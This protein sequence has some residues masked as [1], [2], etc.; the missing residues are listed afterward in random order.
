VIHAR[1]RAGIC[2]AAVLALVATAATDLVVLSTRHP[3]HTP[4]VAAR[5][6]RPAPSHSPLPPALAAPDLALPSHSVPPV[7]AADLRRTRSAPIPPD[8]VAIP[9]QQVVAPI[10]VCAIVEDALQPPADVHRTCRWAGGAGLL[11]AS[12]GAG[13]E[14]TTAITG[15][16]NWV[17][18]G[19]GALGRLAD[20]HRG[21]TV[22]TSDDTGDVTRWRIT[23]VTM[24]DKSRGVDLAAFAGPTGPRVLYLISCGGAF[25]AA[26]LSYVDNVYVR[27]VPD[28][29]AQTHA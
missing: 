25:D 23:S 27:A 12:S 14:G 28:F 15:H 20:L 24:R 11:T 17:G 19:T 4:T 26:E 2:G 7:A 5:L 18:Q 6:I 8:S 21:D 9:G 22:L 1:R 13:S 29:S 10:G 3:S 16:I